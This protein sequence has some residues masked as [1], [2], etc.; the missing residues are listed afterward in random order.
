MR[1]GPDGPRCGLLLV[2]LGAWAEDLIVRKSRADTLKLRFL[3]D[4]LSHT[5]LSSEQQAKGKLK[6]KGEKGVVKGVEKKR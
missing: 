3:V 2:F 5:H 4:F 1:V 6:R